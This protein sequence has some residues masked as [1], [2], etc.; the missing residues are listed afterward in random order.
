MLRDHE[1]RGYIYL[2]CV[3]FLVSLLV[4]LVVTCTAAGNG[5]YRA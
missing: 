5:D 1:T 4:Q 3:A 2:M